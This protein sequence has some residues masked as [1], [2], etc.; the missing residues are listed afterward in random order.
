[1]DLPGLTK[2]SVGDQPGDI[3]QQIQEMI[4]S[5][6]SQDNTIILAVTPANQDIATSKHFTINPSAT[7][8][9]WREK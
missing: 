2:V 4:L 6:I 9:P 7:L 1:M 5:Y 8:T 3:E